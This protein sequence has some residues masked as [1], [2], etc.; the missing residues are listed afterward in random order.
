MVIASNW[1]VC[2]VCDSLETTNPSVVCCSECDEGLCTEC[3][4]SHSVSKA[5]RTHSTIPIAKYKQLPTDILK[6]V[7][8]CSKH[9]EK[10]QIY[11]KKH[12]YPCCHRCV[13]ETHNGCKGIIAICDMIKE[14]ELSNALYNI[15]L[16]L[17]KVA[18]N[19]EKIIKDRK[20]NI[21]SLK[22][23]RRRIENKIQQTRVKIN[24]HLDQI[25][26][27]LMKELNTKDKKEIQK[28]DHLVNSLG[29]R[30]IKKK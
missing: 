16:M 2:G 5:S 19:L 26:D 4:K 8:T 11:C 29:K 18:E 24:S 9:N 22:E 6:I 14:I 27:T 7:H 25:Q 30:K 13:I 10:F 20:D 15:E 12:D 1:T 28:I 17:A 23:Q 3:D 21:T